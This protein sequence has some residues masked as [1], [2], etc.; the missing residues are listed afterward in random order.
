MPDHAPRC[1]L[2][3]RAGPQQSRCVPADDC[4]QLAARLLASDDGAP[5]RALALHRRRPDGGCA[6]CGPRGGPW[7][8]FTASAARE[9]LRQAP[10]PLHIHR[11]RTHP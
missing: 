4:L 11:G 9:A 10:E 7:P 3:R 6:C 8:C 1:A 2:L 5:E